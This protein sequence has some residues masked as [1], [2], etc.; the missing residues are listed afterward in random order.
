MEQAQNQLRNGEN[1]EQKQDAALDRIQDA[2]RAME[3]ER[4]KVEDELVRE[5][6]TR[7][8]DVLKRQREKQAALNAEGVRIQNEVVKRYKAS[9]DREPAGDPG[10]TA[11]ESWGRGLRAS[12]NDLAHNQQ[13][14]GTETASSAG[15]ELANTPVFQKQVQRSA[16]S[17]GL[18]GK[19][20]EEMY[21][22][23]VNN[24]TP[25]LPEDLPDAEATRLQKESLRRLDQLLEAIK[26]ETEALAKR[27]AS[28]GPGGNDNGTG[29]APSGDEGLPPLGQVKL[30]R[31]MQGEVNQA[32][33][34]FQKKNPNMDKLGEKEKAEYQAIQRDQ[35]DVLNLLEALRNPDTQTGAKEGDQ[36]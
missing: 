27:A 8:A 5:Q 29:D 18:A 15:K 6:L 26:S 11:L 30:L 32:I 16:D 17:M 9:T 23:I 19:R 24:R 34:E 22:S 31:A 35:R 2:Q 4:K 25:P 12:L 3:K 33:V 13:D 10:K 1:P 14:L 28:Q 21:T 7:F 20:L 36:K